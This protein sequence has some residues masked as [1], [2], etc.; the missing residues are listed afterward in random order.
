M[1][2]FRFGPRLAAHGYVV[3]QKFAMATSLACTEL[4]KSL[5]L[6]GMIPVLKQ[7]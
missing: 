3:E 5:G 6:K 1:W 4:A 7:P 2:S